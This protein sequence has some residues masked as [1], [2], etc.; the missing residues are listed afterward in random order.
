MSSWGEPEVFHSGNYIALFSASKQTC[1]ALVVCNWMNGCRFT[2]CFLNL[3][4]SDVPTTLFSCYIAD[5]MWNS[6]ILVHILCTPY[7]HAPVHRVI[8]FKT[9]W[10]FSCNLPP[11]LFGRMTG[12]FMCHCGN[13]EVKR[14]P[15]QESAQ[16]VDPGEENSLTTP[17]G[18]WTNDLLVTS[19]VLSHWAIFA[20]QG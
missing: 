20:P 9:A 8:L 2:Q 3:G 18:T 5:A 6:A 19:P 12:V 10:V 11:V 14:I 15:K 7:S 1:C 4:Y 17:A 16:K 13:T